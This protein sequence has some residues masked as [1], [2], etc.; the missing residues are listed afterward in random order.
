[1]SL[2][3]IHKVS[4]LFGD[5]FILEEANLSLE[6]G[7]KA[8]LVGLNGSGKTTLMKIVAGQYEPDGGEVFISA[9]KTMAYSEQ[10]LEMP[11]DQTI[12]SYVLSSFQEVMDLAAEM[13][14]TEIS[15]QK[16]SEA[17]LAPLLEK[18][19][20]LTESF[21]KAGGHSISAQTRK[22]LSGLGFS[23]MHWSKS[24]G[25]LSGGEKRRVSLARILVSQPDILLL[26]EP[27][28]HLDLDAIEWLENYLSSTEATVLL[29]SHDRY[30]LDKVVTRTFAIQN[31]KV[32]SYPGNYSRYEALRREREA[33]DQ[34]AF[35]KEQ[36]E[37]QNIQEYIRKYRAGIK[38][39]Q[40]RGREKQLERRELL[41]GVFP[42]KKI[43]LQF[44][45]PSHT[46]KEVLKVEGLEKQVHPGLRIGPFDFLQM[47]GEV[48][49]II[50]P[51]GSGKTSLLETLVK[52]SQDLGKVKYGS[53][54]R[55]VYFD[56]HHA[57]LHPDNTIF[58][59]IT[60]NFHI[61]FEKARQ[62]LAAILFREEELD[63]K[64]RVLS[65]GEKSR[66]AFIK[67][68]L[69]EP[70]FLILDEPT[71]H[72]D[73]ESK[74][75]MLQSL[76]DFSGTILLVSHDR[77]LLD[78]LCTRLLVVREGQ[79]EVFS[80]TWPEYMEVRA[81]KEKESEKQKTIT[82]R[83]EPQKGAEK[84]TAR[85]PKGY[86]P[87][88]VEKAIAAL[89]E[90]IE[91]LE[92]ELEELHRQIQNPATSRDFQQMNEYSRLLE[93]KE[94]RLNSAYEEWEQQQRLITGE[95]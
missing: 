53:G 70:N 78:L 94:E 51:N 9:G 32:F 56:Q 57:S 74:Q 87:Y 38:S 90:E 2:L 11:K 75:I 42:D 25:C 8:A 93:E 27:T 69:E 63:K 64:I 35:E 30:F 67:M 22:V 26:D 34:R 13:E 66:V 91:R 5:V 85:T 18:Y 83:E 12:F 55:A 43:R 80:G 48:V 40:A 4:K 19:S 1:M 17:E 77:M 86:N 62:M 28:N 50:G 47:A 92:G 73:L 45:E 60:K 14:N 23:Q 15:M 10:N 71:N 7:E 49:G 36:K 31:R 95:E 33:S 3:Q 39:K 88:K 46:G 6:A 52:Q 81:Q 65:G 21:E 20:R 79:V 29:I 54:V 59:E 84:R 58:E 41:E 68:I 24:L 44:Q 89:E 37:I 16:A 76:M 72:L 82:A 61:T